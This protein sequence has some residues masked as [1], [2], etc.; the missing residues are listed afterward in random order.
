MNAREN[1]PDALTPLAA[2]GAMPYITALLGAV[3]R[4]VGLRME[5]DS[6]IS[7]IAGRAYIN[8]NLFMAMAKAMPGVG[9]LSLED[10]FGGQLTPEE[11]RQLAEV[12]AA[13][14]VRRARGIGPFLRLPLLPFWAIRHR[15]AAG[16][17]YVERLNR[18]TDTIQREFDYARMTDTEL[19]TRAT[20][21]LDRLLAGNGWLSFAAVGMGF[22]GS[23]YDTC[24]RWLGD[25]SGAIASRL[26]SGLGE[27][28]AARA[29]VDLWRLS[30]LAAASPELLALIRS[31][32][33]WSVLRPD[34][35]NTAGGLAF[36]TAWDDFMFR[37]G[38]HCRGELDIGRARWHEQP[39]YVLATVRTYLDAGDTVN[40]ET[41]RTR[42]ARERATLLQ[43]C[44]AR[45]KNPV[46]RLVF[47]FIAAR[48]QAGAPIREN[49]KSVAI[50][51]VAL[52]RRAVV[53]L[54]RRLAERGV[55]ETDDDVFYLTLEELRRMV[56]PS[57]LPGV[58]DLIARRRT[59]HERNLKLTPP[60]IVFGTFDP[61][62]T[63]TAETLTVT[64]TMSGIAVSPGIATGPAR[65]ITESDSGAQVLPGE[66]LVCPHTDPGWTPLFLSA[67]GLVVDMGGLLSH[68][69]IIAR[70]YG[71]PAVVNVGPATRI[72][73][74]G[75]HVQVD[76]NTGT[77]R[78]LDNPNA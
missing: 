39:D 15:P 7:L 62:Q 21:P 64:G 60:S 36:L 5:T 49:I 53:E 56:E 65:V 76:G 16:R 26:L 32:R 54:G 47:A 77:V 43:E 10:I 71:I 38:H 11:A 44:R 72:I 59:E 33:P 27:F 19:V 78:I 42:N 14:P 48:A 17:R 1:L 75:Q 28:E 74:T 25:S 68:G 12:A 52:L 55:I 63:T 40:P 22:H 70:E 67:A 24:R 18:E 66:I 35:E 23:L 6:I 50:R 29:G 61:D 8:L 4:I 3:F 13:V 30:R 41:D 37:H 9:R 45:L 58:R 73:K 69:S 57:G 34:V 20:E 46:R 31:A 2:A 51:R